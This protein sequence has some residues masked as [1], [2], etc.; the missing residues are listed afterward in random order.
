MALKSILVKSK[1]NLSTTN[2]LECSVCE[3]RFFMTSRYLD[4]MAT[5]KHFS[6]SCNICNKGFLN[7]KDLDEHYLTHSEVINTYD[8]NKCSKKFLQKYEL[9]QHIQSLCTALNEPPQKKRKTVHFNTELEL[10]NVDDFSDFESEYSESDE[11]FTEDYIPYKIFTQTRS[12]RVVKAKKIFENEVEI[13]PKYPRKSHE[14]HSG[15]SAVT[16]DNE[17]LVT[18]SIENSNVEYE[19]ENAD[20][21]ST[22][23]NSKRKLVAAKRLCVLVEKLP[24]H[25]YKEYIEKGNICMYKN[26][27]QADEKVFE[28]KK[29]TENVNQV[30]SLSPN[31]FSNRGPISFSLWAKTQEKKEI[32]KMKENIT[33]NTVEPSKLGSL[34]KRSSMKLAT[35]SRSQNKLSDVTADIAKIKNSFPSVPSNVF[36]VIKKEYV[37]VGANP[38]VS[39]IKEVIR[40]MEIMSKDKISCISNNLHPTVCNKNLNVSRS[41]LASS[42]NIP[43]TCQSTVSND[44]NQKNTASTSKNTLNANLP[45][46]SHEGILGKKVVQGITFIKVTEEYMKKIQKQNFQA[47]ADMKSK[48]EALSISDEV[49]MITSSKNSVSISKVE[50]KDNQTQEITPVTNID[51]PS[52]SGSTVSHK[53]PVNADIKLAEESSS[54]CIS[55]KIPCTQQSIEDVKIDKLSELEALSVMSNNEKLFERYKAKLEEKERKKKEKYEFKKKL[56]YM[57]KLL[58][59]NINTKKGDNDKIQSSKLAEDCEIQPRDIAKVYSDEKKKSAECSQKNREK[60]KLIALEKCSVS[61]NVLAEPLPEE[62]KQ[63]RTN[64]EAMEAAKHISSKFTVKLSEE[65]Y[66][67]LFSNLDILI[68]RFNIAEKCQFLTTVVRF[69]HTYV[70]NCKVKERANAFAAKLSKFKS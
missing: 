9:V 21:N 18:P 23:V 33:I 70:K 16:N 66:F 41:N 3:K 12:G 55:E 40:E 38:N 4:H 10:R 34:N 5:H 53:I 39:Q 30:C 60:D 11:D 24:D 32:N 28:I 57:A 64:E 8:C 52:T 42:A 69:C 19:T 43:V 65:E 46:E 56:R 50:T 36:P 13:K 29:E 35:T 44:M 54:K 20:Q 51:M 37:F 58:G 45:V 63:V 1:Q 22:I 62:L 68:T 25:T 17:H 48:N 15:K 7:Q 59:E 31:N 61:H 6:L 47:S 26:G 49:S 14:L 2:R 67:K 27:N